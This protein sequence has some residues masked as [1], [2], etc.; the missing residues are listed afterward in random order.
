M[1]GCQSAPAQLFYDF[2]LGD[3]VP[4]DH[5]LRG[6]DQHLELDSARAQLK[7]FYS[8]TGRPSVDPEL[9]MRMRRIRSWSA[10]ILQPSPPWIRLT[11]LSKQADYHSRIYRVQQ[12]GIWIA[13]LLQQTAASGL[14]P[15][16]SVR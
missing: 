16:E 10:P 11:S 6:I 2:C 5:L 3:H 9:M 13:E 15:L 4:A 7:P 12:C 14:R 8:T 1:M